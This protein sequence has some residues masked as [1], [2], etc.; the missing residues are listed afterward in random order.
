MFV[1]SLNFCV[2]L[3]LSPCFYVRTPWF[4]QSVKQKNQVKNG[5]KKFSIC[6]K[7][8]KWRISGSSNLE[9]NPRH[10]KRLQKKGFAFWGKE[11]SMNQRSLT[12]EWRDWDMEWGRSGDQEGVD[13]GVRFTMTRIRAVRNPVR[14]PGF[15]TTSPGIISVPD[16]CPG[17]TD[18][19][20]LFPI[21]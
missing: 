11:L 10:K 12:N 5:K 7:K 19:D 18:P 6:K 9:I 20:F 4:H 1:A 15:R 14:N 21:H 13:C 3:W 8:Q 17:K 2:T 16:F